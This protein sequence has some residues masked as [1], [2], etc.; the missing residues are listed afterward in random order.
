M[1]DKAP[2]KT[3]QI[4]Y[5]LLIA[6]SVVVAI[7]VAFSS[8]APTFFLKES[9]L[10]IEIGE[11]FDPLSQ[12]SSLR[13]VELSDIEISSDVDCQKVGTYTVTY[14]YLYKTQ[15][16]T[17][18][19]EDRDYPVFS[20]KD[21]QDFYMSSTFDI[22]N[23]VINITDKTGVTDFSWK[24]ISGG[25]G[26]P[27]PAVLQLK[28]SDAYGH[29]TTNK[30]TVN[31]IDDI[32]P[33]LMLKS[34]TE[35]VEAG[36]DFDP[37]VFVETATDNYGT[38]E[39]TYKINSGTL[40]KV[41]KVKATL[42]ATDTAGNVT[43]AEVSFTTVDTT[44]PKV[45]EKAE[46]H[47]HKMSKKLDPT[48]YFDIT[49]NSEKIKT[50]YE[51]ISGSL[52]EIGTATVAVTV[53]DYYG[54]TTDAGTI[55]IEV[56]DDI[57]PVL[58]L[59]QSSYV[60]DLG[61]SIDL[62]L[63]VASAI[64]NSGEDV[65][66]SYKIK[67]GSLEHAGKVTFDVIATDIYGNSASVTTYVTIV[68]RVAP[69]L[70]LKRTSA[71]HIIGES[72]K[73]ED[74]VKSCTDNDA[75]VSITMQVISGSLDKHGDVVIEITAKDPSGNTTVKKV[76][77]KSKDRL[78]QDFGTEEKVDITGIDDQP[79]LI[80]VNRYMGVVTI[81]GKDEEWNYTVP[82]MAM[83]CSVGKNSAL[84]ENFGVRS[85][86]GLTP[87][88][89]Y[90]TNWKPSNGWHTLYS[91]DDY[92]KYVY[93][94]YAVRIKD[95]IL[96]H[97]VPYF[98][99]RKD[100]LEWSGTPDN[101][102]HEFNKL[103]S[104]ASMG[105]VRLCVRDVK[106]IYDNCPLGA[107]VVIYDEKDNYGPLGRPENFIIDPTSE[108]FADVDPEI[109]KLSGYYKDTFT[110]NPDASL[111]PLNWD[112][113]D[114]DPNNPWIPLLEAWEKKQQEEKENEEESSDD[115]APKDKNTHR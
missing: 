106:W 78:Y 25:I 110:K 36:D 20:I 66:L 45:V 99:Q 51:L 113:T 14:K 73:A 92:H 6:I 53:S 104:P 24:E 1:R 18:V 4:V 115:E 55:T 10:S 35:K 22:N 112:P 103:G 89:I 34:F 98:W 77:V 5:G 101:L 33:V 43:S 41:G 54:N 86:K 83:L 102:D 47:K 80:A 19:V 42:Y 52:T 107:V 7:V 72:I 8:L 85:G 82:V 57:P 87:L 96:F 48:L 12:I 67:S 32:P 65:T 76:D 23:I 30:V 95:A 49:D 27:G 94:Q 97:S 84:P 105:C 40:S 39:V 75:V 100:A 3:K 44:P 58:K 37:M 64:D 17:V 16:L 13:N 111:N 50:S 60:M 28:A 90:N 62:N 71:T 9:K 59:T 46:T 15:T 29:V 114:P 56:E 63:V 93:G 79:Y 11:S 74:F 69:N 88:G 21:N 38:P 26:I 108:M 109:L 31:V 61:R 81:Y 2:S 68:D 91:N 70:V